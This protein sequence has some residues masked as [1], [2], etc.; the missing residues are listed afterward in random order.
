MKHEKMTADRPKVDYETAWDSYAKQWQQTNSQ[1]AHIGDEWIGKAAGAANS[2]TEYETLIEQQFI[3]PYIKQEHTVLEI[4]IGGG[5]TGALLLKYCDRLI[6][7]DISSQMLQATRDRLGV[8]RVAYVKLDGLTLDSIAPN[9]ADV[10]FC[11][12]TMVH[13]EPVD[14]FNYL[15][16]IPKLLRGDRLCVFHHSNILSELGWQKFASEWDKNLLAGRDGTA[17]S[18]MT[19]T[20]MEKFLTH[21]NYEILLKNT[22]SVPRDCVWICKAPS[23]S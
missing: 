14:I 2:L 1:L 7:A 23:N 22:T 3:A 6:C 9:S 11:Y 4:G 8:D 13:V 21:L 15:T 16:R 12:D 20:I 18:V 19:D 5:K 10:C 17:F